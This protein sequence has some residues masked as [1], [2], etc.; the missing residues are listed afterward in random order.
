MK[1]WAGVATVGVLM[2][3]G[4]EALCLFGPLRYERLIHRVC[5]GI[6]YSGI[7]LVV[8]AAVVSRNRT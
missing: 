1:R 6:F 8:L 5:H 7:V 3:F 4:G 2:I